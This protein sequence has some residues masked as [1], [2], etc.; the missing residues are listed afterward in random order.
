[1]QLPIV[2]AEHQLDPTQAAP[3][4]VSAQLTFDGTAG[5]TYYYDT[6]SFTPGDIMQIGLQANATGLSTG[7]YSYTETIIDYRGGTPTTFTYSGTATVENAAQDPTFAALGAGWTISGL[8]KIISAS[9]GVIVNDG[10]GV[11]EWFSDSFGSGGGTFTSPAGDFS[12][13]TQNSGGGYTQTFTDG[14]ELNFNSSGFETT[15]V[16]RNGLTTTFTYSGNLLSSITDPFSQ[17]VTFTYNGSNQLQSIKDS[18]SRLAT[19]TV[20]GGDLTAVEYP[21]G[22]TWDYGYNGSNELT[23]VTEPSSAGEP[24]KITTI[25]YDNAERVGTITRADSTTE[26]YSAAQEQ[27]WTNSGTSGSPAAST[28]LAEVGSTYTDPLSDVT[29]LRPDWRGMGLTDQ[30]VN[31]LSNVSTY[32]RDSNGLATIVIDP[33]NR[34]SQYA[35]DTH[36]NVTQITYPDLSTVTYGT[37]NSFAEP[38]SM[39]DQLSRTDTYTYDSE[40]NLTVLEDPMDYVTTYT[41]S[42]T[43]PGILTAQTA[44]ALVGHSS[45]TLFSYQYDSYDR[46]TTTTNADSDVTVNAYSSA[47]QLTSVTDANSNKTTYSYDAMNRETG[48]T[49][50][51][52]SAIAGVTTY[53]YDAG[54]NQTTET[55]PTGYTTT[56]TYDALDR[57]STVENADDVI[58]IY[59]YDNAGRL[60]VLTDA[61]SNATTFTYN[62]LGEETEVTSP[63]VNSSGGVSATFVYDADGELVDS[64]DADGRRTTYSFDSLGDETGETWLNSSGGAIYTATFTYDLAGELTGADDANATLTMAYDSDGQLATMVTS[65]PGTGQPTVTLTYGY[66]P[67]GDV[68]SIKDSLS[69]SGGTGQG[70]TT[71]QYDPA[72]RLTT[73]TQSLGG[74]TYGEITITYDSGGRM[75]KEYES[76]DATGTIVI[77]GDSYDAANDITGISSTTGT[78]GSP[79]IHTTFVSDSP[80]YNSAGELTQYA[81]T[82]SGYNV[83]N[84]YTYDHAGQLT[85]STGTVNDSYSYDLDGNRDSSG[86]TTGTGNEMTASPGYTYTYDNDGNL[87]SSTNTSTSVTTTYTYGYENRLTNVTV[88]GTVMATYTY[89]A[90]GQRIGIDDSSAQTWTV[91]NGTSPDANPYADFNGTGGV[92]VRYLDGLAVNELFA[93]T[94]S[95][96]NLAWYLTDQLGSVTDLVSSSGT[97]LDHIVYDPYGNIVTETD[98]SNGDRFKFAGIEYDSTTGIYYDHARYYDAAIGRFMSQDP[99]GSRPGMRTFTDTW[100][101]TRQVLW[102]PTD[103]KNFHTPNIIPE[104]GTA[105]RGRAPRGRVAAE[106]V[107]V[108][109][110]VGTVAISLGLGAAVL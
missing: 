40:G 29:T 103:Y 15:S 61:D 7:R 90:L 50:A 86:Y 63:S 51:A 68:T 6:S 74:T 105:A 57:V 85:G 83:L 14:T 58:T 82:Y 66:D 79:F 48:M 44:P 1:M 26:T 64:T 96:G 71:Y 35:Y 87:I 39:T 89:N 2:V 88:G 81:Q 97:D 10:G 60:H 54:G 11:V 77:T 100:R 104:S 28:L 4:E 47:G 37:Y 30:S 56:T 46:L 42:N 75:T 22:S 59:T 92:T 91:Y 70:I 20:S 69:G 34:I 18:A 65:G 3:S 93:R 12:T 8:E 21:D 76:E 108:T 52:G 62:A 53:G 38:S 49:T 99:A 45:Y 31:A 95:G 41:Y 72:L 78:E 73:V 19:F 17:T 33:M 36:G 5:S 80:T 101:T 32:D 67:S 13:L 110:T 9:G 23:S 25:T 106:S 27:G 102:T 107:M 16:D 55:A 43:Q 94:S 109:T 24:T 98:S 84:T